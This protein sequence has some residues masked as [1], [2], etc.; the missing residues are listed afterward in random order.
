MFSKIQRSLGSICMFLNPDEHIIPMEST[1]YPFS[2]DDLWMMEDTGIKT[3]YVTHTFYWEKIWNRDTCDLDWSSADAKVEKYLHT[4]LKIMLPFYVTMPRWFPDGWYIDKSSEIDTHIIPN[5]ANKNLQETIDEF[6]NEILVHYA[7]I[8]DR[9]HLTY[10]IPAGGEF[11]WDA[12]KIDNYPVSDEDLFEFVIGRQRLLSKQYGEVWSVFHNFLGHPMNWNNIHLPYLYQAMR[13]EFPLLPIYS[14]QGPHFSVGKKDYYTD[15]KNQAKVT[16][17]TDKYGI[18]FFVGP[19]YCE[20]LLKNIDKA[21]EQKVYGF[22]P[23]PLGEENTVLHTSVEQWMCD[24]MR[25]ANDI[26]K[27]NYG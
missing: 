10:A 14:I 16:E 18:K 17:Y 20:G 21:I 15:E 25:I 19:D 26:F 24:N 3:I 4:N 9:I 7:D 12:N 11:L 23:A 27:E 22:L 5:Y 1:I 6:A 2:I 13:D 8:R